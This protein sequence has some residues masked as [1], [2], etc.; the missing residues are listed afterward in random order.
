[1]ARPDWQ[2]ALYAR[3]ADERLM[4]V[5]ALL[6]RV[7]LEDPRRI[8]DL[9]CGAGASTA[10]LLARW[11]NADV[12]GVDT[13][14]AM[15][16][17]AREKVPGV[18]FVAADAATFDPGGLV[19]LLFANALLQWIPDHAGLLPRLMARLAPGG[20]LAVQI[21]DNLDEPSHALMRAVAATQP[22]A[23]KL[24]GAA[25]ERTAIPDT[26]AL[27]D[28][29]APLSSRVE[30]WRTTYTHVLDGAPAIAEMLR[31]TGLKPFLDPLDPAEREAFLA[32]YRARLAEAYPRQADG[33]VLLRFPRLFYVAVKRG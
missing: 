8:V 23:A 15:L 14:E 9:G 22:F 33:K 29:L 24:A 2:P 31:S 11:P 30:I 25:G 13:S 5:E 16:A 27:Y 26:T 4:P 32:D 21:P 20:V 3:F 18:R 1:M 10:P 7:P 19:D 6:A 12:V 17:A 28:V